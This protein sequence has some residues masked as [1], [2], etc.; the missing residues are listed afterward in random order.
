MGRAT[1]NRDHGVLAPGRYGTFSWFGQKEPRFAVYWLPPLVYFAVGLITRF[2]R[3]GRLRVAMRVA[4]GGLIV[5]L[6]IPA[7][8]TKDLTLVDIRTLRHGS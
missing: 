8:A 4:S 1:A 7:G 5:V 3:P 2:F 6:A